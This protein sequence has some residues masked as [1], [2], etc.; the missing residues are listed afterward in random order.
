MDATSIHV[1]GAA[2]I[3]SACK[4]LLR[5][6]VNQEFVFVMTFFYQVF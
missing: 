5:V 6:V 1:C 4:F 2:A 3:N